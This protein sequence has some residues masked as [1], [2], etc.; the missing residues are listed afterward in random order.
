MNVEVCRPGELGGPELER[1]RELIAT[2][3]GLDDPFL[4]PEFARL[5][6]RVRPAARVAV[7]HDGPQIAAFLAFEQGRLGTMRPIGA[8]VSDR[9]AVI[10]AP[11]TAIDHR[12]L[13][14][15][16]G[17]GAW[18]FDHLR[19]ADVPPDARAVAR[20]A[21]PLADLSGGF[22]AYLAERRSSKR[23]R[24]LVRQARKL[25]EAEPDLTFWLDHRDRAYLHR[26]MAWKSA[27]YRRTGRRDRFAQRWIAELCDVLFDERSPGCRGTLA[28]LA[29]G[30]RPLAISFS[31]RTPS[32]L[33]WW[34]PA[35]DPAF[36]R[37]SAGLVLFLRMAEAAAA[38]G[39]AQIDMGR[40]DEPYKTSLRTGELMVA[41]GTLACRPAAALWTRRREPWRRAEDA[42]LARPAL[43]VAARRVLAGA[44][45]VRTM[46]TP[47][48]RHDPRPGSGW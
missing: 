3:P 6:G 26:L 1:W 23:V 37:H 4:A 20:H 9:Q 30:D 29:A 12:A 27:Q 8:G 33:S 5:V 44:G 18:E 45:R 40:G 42:V 46:T 10:R 7:V 34:F 32:A 39:I 13:L 28:V 17:Q 21:S 14:R 31:L 24:N 2:D 35:Y 47:R 16:A 25:D 36:A 48:G 22:D 43:R 15:A 41:E 38:D 11:G 19:D